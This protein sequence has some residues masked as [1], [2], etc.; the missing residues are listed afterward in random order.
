MSTGRRDGVEPV[1]P[2]PPTEDG[3]Y[4]REI[5]NYSPVIVPPSIVVRGSAPIPRPPSSASV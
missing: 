1:D 4:Y 5:G 3:K 2:S